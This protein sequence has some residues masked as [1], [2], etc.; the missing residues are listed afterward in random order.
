MALLGLGRD[1]A[2]ALAAAKDPPIQVWLEAWSSGLGLPR[3]D[4]LYLVKELLGDQ[5]LV[6]AFVKLALPPDYAAVEGLREHQ[7]EP[8]TGKG[9]TVAGQE[10]DVLGNHRHLVKGVLARGVDTEKLPDVWCTFGVRVDRLG[11]A[12]VEVSNW[13]EERPDALG[14]LAAMASLDVLAQVVHIVLGLIEERPEHEHPRGGAFK[15]EGREL[16]VG[17]AAGVHKVDDS[18]CVDG[19]A[20]KSIWVPSNDAGCFSRLDAGEHL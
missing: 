3:H 8:S 18:A 15:G 7:V 14:N 13:G 4:R 12:V 17:K 10:P 20:G 5:G 16:Q 9:F 19:I 1:E 6:P 11:D 2:S